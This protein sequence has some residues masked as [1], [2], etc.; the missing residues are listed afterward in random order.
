MAIAGY[1]A[2]VRSAGASTTVSGE[3]CT[4]V[5]G[6]KYQITS[7]A[8]RL[9][10]PLATWVFKDG[11]VDIP[12]ASI[13]TVDFLFGEVTL[14]APAAGAVTFS[15]DFYPITTA[16][17]IVAEVKGFGL[18]FT[19][20]VLD[21]T[22]LNA[23]ASNLRKKTVGLKTATLSLDLLLNSTDDLKLSTYQSNGN[24]LAV[25]INFGSTPLFRGI[26]WVGEY[27]RSG[28]VDGLLEATATWDVSGEQETI[29]GRK[30]LYGYSERGLTST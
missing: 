18:S 4:N 28:S 12:Y 22:V 29:S 16:S 9:L 3:A 23:N 5:S 19:T 21:K 17:E 25:D 1:K 10:N 6:A 11:G 7:S 20:D 15:G 13:A 26:G 30:F 8:R 2:L 27:N 14:T 24:L